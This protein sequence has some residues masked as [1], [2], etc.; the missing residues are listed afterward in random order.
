[1]QRM[2]YLLLAALFLLLFVARLVTDGMFIDGVVYATLANNLANGIGS[3]WALKHAERLY[4]SFYEHPPLMP[5]LQS[6]FFKVLGSGYL[7]ERVYCLVVSLL[8]MLLMARIWQRILPGSPLRNWWPLP[9]FF[10]MLNEDAYLSYTSNMLEC[11]MTLFNLGAVLCL[12]RWYAGTT[13]A[14]GAALA[15]AAVLTILAFLTKGPAGLYPLAFFGAFAVLKDE[16]NWKKLATPTIFLTALTAGGLGLL[17]LHEPAR[18]CLSAYFN[19]QVMAAITGKRTEN[20]APHRFY[21]LQR[22]LETHAHFIGLLGLI[23][24]FALKK[25]GVRVATET[26]PAVRFFAVLA[27]AALLPVMISPKQAPHY[28]VPALPWIALALGAALAGILQPLRRVIV[29]AAAT[30]A[31]GGLVVAAAFFAFSQRHKVRSDLAELKPLFAHIPPYASVGFFEKNHALVLNSY[32]QRYNFNDVDRF[33]Y[34]H[35]YLIFETGQ[36]LPPELVNDFEEITVSTKKYKLYKH[37][38]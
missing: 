11:T 4:S 21:M 23:W 26:L 24:Y 35:Q 10:W 2:L 7:T 22:F 15:G 37:V 3:F 31:V 6:L 25:R 9:L 5:G 16:W 18:A 8:T 13:A 19:Q 20:I 36:Q 1:M 33:G 28:I 14:R 32:F 27:A 30:W 38:Q 17:L 12:L 34:Q 29:P